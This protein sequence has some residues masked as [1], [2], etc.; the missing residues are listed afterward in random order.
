V[1]LVLFKLF[2]TIGVFNMKVAPYY[3][4][5]GLRPNATAANFGDEITS[6]IAG[7]INRGSFN[8]L[9]LIDPSSGHNAVFNRGRL[10][11]TPGFQYNYVRAM[12]LAHEKNKGMGSAFIDP[13]FGGLG[14]AFT[15]FRDTIEGAIMG[16]AATAVTPPATVPKPVV[17]TFMGLTYTTIGLLG[18]G[19]LLA[20]KFLRK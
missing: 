2:L 10:N 14:S 7:I 5:R 17:P 12:N 11:G 4:M 9:P 15:D 16:T 6:G 19:S 18:F 13:R 8:G 1:P 3:S 20:Y